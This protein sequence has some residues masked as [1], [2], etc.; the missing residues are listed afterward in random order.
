MQQTYID[1]DDL[2]MIKQK[3]TTTGGGRNASLN[4]H[5]GDYD[6]EVYDLGTA[7]GGYPT[8]SAANTIPLNDH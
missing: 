3:Q 5:F 1:N 2:N 7:Y 4:S 8:G 6:K